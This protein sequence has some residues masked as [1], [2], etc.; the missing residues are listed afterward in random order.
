LATTATGLDPSVVE[1]QAPVPEG[2]V[3]ANP[4]S[5]GSESSESEVGGRSK[6][7]VR[8]LSLVVLLVGLVLTGALAWAA[9]ATNNDNENRLLNLQVKQVA[10]ALAAAIPSDQAPLAAADQLLAAGADLASFKSFATTQLAPKGRF[11]S[12]SLWQLGEGAPHT[13]AVVGETPYF[14]GH[15]AQAQRFFAGVRPSSTLSVTGILP[16]SPRRLGYAEALPG[17]TH[18]LVVFGENPLPPKNQVRIVKK[19]SAF[20]DL[21]F[22][23]YLGGTK[24]AASLIEATVPLPVRGRQ[25]TA[26]VPFGDT[27]ITF[28]STPTGPLGGGGGQELPWVTLLIGALLSLA[29]ALIAEH[30]VRRREFAE[31][32]AA[33]NQRL[34]SNQRGIA[35]TLQHALLPPELPV[36]PGA[37]LA[38]RYLPGVHGVEIG[39]DWYD[40]IALDPDHCFFVV[41]DVSGRGLPAATTMA[42]LRYAIKAYVNQGD[43]PE[44]VL[45]KLDELVSVGRD[46]RFA[47]V[48]CGHIDVPNHRVTLSSAGHPPPL[49]ID[50]GGAHFIDMPIGTPVGVTRGMTRTSFS[51]TV[52]SRTTLLAFTDG[53]IERRGESLSAGLERLRVSATG[54]DGPVEG[55]LTRVIDDLTPEGSDDDIA[56]LGVRWLT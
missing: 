21:N 48:L 56:I 27:A 23:L 6:L 50:D 11:G 24:D 33:E 10:A 44:S 37:E 19:G 38:V 4:A 43:E 26:T 30:L 52:S 54:G 31:A 51:A 15:P 46:G 8:R 55:L 36:V 2:P 35:E 7:S 3:A 13:L 18:G 40:V 9:A 12:I 17:E 41:G 20:A 34:Y 1:A 49:L 32:L 47:T 45:R 5:S 22:V 28:V 25:A 42:Y 53:L 29:A 39:G 16:G 14:A